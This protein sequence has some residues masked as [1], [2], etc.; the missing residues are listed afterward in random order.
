MIASDTTGK[1][2]VVSELL[3]EMQVSVCRAWYEGITG[4]L[5]IL[6]LFLMGMAVTKPAVKSTWALDLY[7][8]LVD[9]QIE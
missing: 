8:I 6:L 5:F 3:F 1:T 4:P 9:W 2:L 7:G